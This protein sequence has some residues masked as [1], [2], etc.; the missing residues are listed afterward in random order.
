VYVSASNLKQIV[1]ECQE[2]G[3]PDDR[4]FGIAAE[5]AKGLV[6][7]YGYTI[8]LDD[9]KQAAHLTALRV[10]QKIRTDKDANTFSYLT[11]CI[12]NDLRALVR[13]HCVQQN[14]L[15]QVEELM[16]PDR[17]RGRS[18]RPIGGE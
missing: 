16:R 18:G 5:I 3:V 15:A 9:A 1:R 17:R 11:T 4:L 10:L 14:L 2:A 8:D 7:K 12:R 6:G 13:Q